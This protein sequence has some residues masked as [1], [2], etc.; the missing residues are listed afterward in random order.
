MRGCIRIINDDEWVSFESLTILE[1]MK[2]QNDMKKIIIIF[3]INLLTDII[4]LLCVVID[5][6]YEIYVICI[7]IYKHQPK[8]H[9]DQINFQVHTCYLL[10]SEKTKKKCVV[11]AVAS[12][13]IMSKYMFFSLFHSELVY[14]CLSL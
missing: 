9:S 8:C 3:I 7:F 4:F 14:P 10:L 1:A 6:S 12:C 5:N 2:S 13:G 11:N